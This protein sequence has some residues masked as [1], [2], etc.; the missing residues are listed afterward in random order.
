MHYREGPGQRPIHT[1]EAVSDGS[2]AARFGAVALLTM[3][4]G[5]A[6]LG[7]V[8]ADIYCTRNQGAARCVLHRHYVGRTEQTLVTGGHQREP[9]DER[10]QTPMVP[11]GLHHGSGATATYEVLVADN[12]LVFDAR[13]F[14]DAIDAPA[15]RGRWVQGN[16]AF[17]EATLQFHEFD[18]PGVFVRHRPASAAFNVGACL[19]AAALSAALLAFAAARRRRYRLRF[20]PNS[21]TV[22]VS[23]G[24]LFALGPEREVKLSTSAEP[25]VRFVRDGVEFRSGDN[26]LFT[27]PDPVERG[28]LDSLRHSIERAR[29]PIKT[30][31]TPLP[32]ALYAVLP[33]LLTVA[34]TVIVVGAVRH[35]RSVPSDEGTISLRATQQ[36]NYGGVSLLPGGSMQWRVRAGTHP[37]QLTS[38]R[39]LSVTVQAHV[40]PDATTEI[41]CN[42]ALFSQRA[43]A[44]R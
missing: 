35:V 8:G 7:S 12:P 33:A 43:P 26:V 15:Q 30:V 6:M 27:S 19:A 23:Q 31:A 16:E 25:T 3:S 32:V 21:E 34:A 39:G 5:L 41:E 28:L 22:F 44:A 4:V 17:R 24:T 40:A 18:S 36:C 29:G 37:L 42:D 9:G 11:L 14:R 10:R 1:F 2:R 20:D 13:W 38:P